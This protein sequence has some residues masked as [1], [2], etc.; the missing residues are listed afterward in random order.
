MPFFY[1]RRFKDSIAEPAAIKVE[2]ATAS[3]AVGMVHGA[4]VAETVKVT[5]PL[6]YQVAPADDLNRK[7]GFCPSAGQAPTGKLVG[8]LG[9]IIGGED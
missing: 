6:F 3:N 5:A 2:A 8:N 7:Q 4:P 1:V 9:R